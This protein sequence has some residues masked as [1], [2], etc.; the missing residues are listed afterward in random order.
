MGGYIVLMAGVV[1]VS[2][3]LAMQAWNA[4]KIR[5][6]N[7]E[8]DRAV[9]N[10]RRLFVQFAE[11]VIGTMKADR[12]ARVAEAELH[13]RAIAQSCRFEKTHHPP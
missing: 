9:Q 2:F 5:R 3:A 7:D 12:A 4:V 1:F 10:D 6:L 8:H 11:E 13:R